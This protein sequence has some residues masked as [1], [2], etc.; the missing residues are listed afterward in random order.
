MSTGDGLHFSIVIVG[1]GGPI[2]IPAKLVAGKSVTSTYKLNSYFFFCV[3]V[4]APFI[5]KCKGSGDTSNFDDYEEEVLRISSTERCAK[6]F[7]EF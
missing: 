1:R 3:Q 5:P 7:A 4:E 2:F 6:E